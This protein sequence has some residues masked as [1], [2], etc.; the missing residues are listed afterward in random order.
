MPLVVLS[1]GKRIQDADIA[2]IAGYLPQWQTVASNLGMGQLDI[3]DIANNDRTPADQRKSF[4]RKRISRDGNA[5]T[6]EKLSEV[7]ETLGEQGAADAI[8]GIATD[9]LELQQG[10]ALL[11]WSLYN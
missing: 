10:T 6:Y 3:E 9:S 1:T 8:R 2:R 7:L 4:L 11:Q 5:A